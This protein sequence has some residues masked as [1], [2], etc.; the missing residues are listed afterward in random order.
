MLPLKTILARSCKEAFMLSRVIS[1]SR[2]PVRPLPFW[3]LRTVAQ[4]VGHAFEPE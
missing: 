3:L 1:A 2:D 4:F